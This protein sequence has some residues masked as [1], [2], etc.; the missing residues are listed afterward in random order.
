MRIHKEF[1]FDSA[2]YLPNLPD[3]HKCGN[4]HGH[5]FTVELHIEG[6]ADVYSGWVK[7]FGEIDRQFKPVLEE[8]DHCCLNEISGLSNPT[9]ENIAIWIWD[10]IESLYPGLFQVTVKETPTSSASYRGPDNE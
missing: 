5:T 3:G 8:L 4:L 1:R 9:S 10:R 2:H 6:K 7:D